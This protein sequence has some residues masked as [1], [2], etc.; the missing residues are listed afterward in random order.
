LCVIRYISQ[1][2]SILREVCFFYKRR[3]DHILRTGDCWTIFV[4]YKSFTIFVCYKIYFTECKYIARSLFFF[5]YKRRR[6]HI[7]RTGDCW[8]I[9]VCYKSFTIFVC[10]KIYFTECKYIARSLFFFI[11]EEGIISW[12]QE[13]AEQYLYVIRVSQYLCVIRYIFTECKYIAKSLFFFEK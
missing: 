5:I 6:D 12:E 10:Y 8:T 11:K 13:T 3:R 1:S 2:V 4:C 9:F 7:L